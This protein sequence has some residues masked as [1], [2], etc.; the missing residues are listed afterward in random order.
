MSRNGQES[1]R[2]WKRTHLTGGYQYQGGTLVE[3]IDQLKATFEDRNGKET[4]F[5]RLANTRQ[6][7]TPLADYIQT[8]ELN[9]EEAGYQVGNPLND[10]FLCQTITVLVTEEVRAKLFASGTA[11]PRVYGDLKERLL[12]IS[13]VMEQENS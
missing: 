6:G 9:A 5:M 12:V 10:T 3:L 7:K 1:V 2:N 11:I 8:F 13:G 4:A